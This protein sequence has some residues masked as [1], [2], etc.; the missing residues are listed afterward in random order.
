MNGRVYL[1][2]FT[3]GWDLSKILYG[4]MTILCYYLYRFK[5]GESIES[6]RVCMVLI[7]RGFGDWV[8][9]LLGKEGSF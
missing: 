4:G 3:R 5:K 9:I 8:L 1:A 7:S 6:L 2:A